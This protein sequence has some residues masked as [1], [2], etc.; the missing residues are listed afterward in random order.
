MLLTIS[1]PAPPCIHTRTAQYYKNLA[2]PERR[3]ASLVRL[4]TI[5]KAEFTVS[6]AIAQRRV[7]LQHDLA[8]EHDTKPELRMLD[9]LEK[10]AVGTIS[11]EEFT[12][13][14]CDLGEITLPKETP[15]F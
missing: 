3:V 15:V 6:Y 11:P 4:K 7:I 12:T 10:L 9:V 1:L 5:P 2:A 13:K 14:Y 8:Y